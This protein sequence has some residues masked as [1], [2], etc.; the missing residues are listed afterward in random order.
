ML[1]RTEENQGLETKTLVRAFLGAEEI[2]QVNLHPVDVEVSHVEKYQVWPLFAKLYEKLLGRIVSVPF[3][4]H[5]KILRIFLCESLLKQVKEN[6]LFLY[7]QNILDFALY[8]SKFAIAN[9]RPL[10]R[11]NFIAE[12]QLVLRYLNDDVPEGQSFVRLMQVQLLSLQIQ[13][14]QNVLYKIVSV[15]L[16][17]ENV[18]VLVEYLSLLYANRKSLDNSL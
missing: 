12:T 2:I 8:Y 9:L 18:L 5:E 13:D 15:L 3:S 4:G 11:E 16:G 1:S 10:L 7:Q 6:G 17:L 14:K